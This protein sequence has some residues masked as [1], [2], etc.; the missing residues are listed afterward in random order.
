MEISKKLSDLS[1]V[2]DSLLKRINELQNSEE[3]LSLNELNVIVNMTTKIANALSTIEL[4]QYEFTLKEDIDF[5]HPKIQKGMQFLVSAFIE[6]LQDTDLDPETT[7]EVANNLSIKLFDFENRLNKSLKN[8][9]MNAVE[10]A[11]NPLV[12]QIIN[13]G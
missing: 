3:E 9:R 1:T 6:S 2:L 10:Y 5:H 13:R 8:I 12:K 7:Q 11:T 4:K